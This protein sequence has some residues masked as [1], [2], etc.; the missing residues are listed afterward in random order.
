MYAY[1]YS[2]TRIRFAQK[3]HILTKHTYT[4]LKRDVEGSSTRN[5]FRMHAKQFLRVVFLK[6][7]MQHGLTSI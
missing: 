5:M 3:I 6:D 7:R 1:I 4:S 2:Q